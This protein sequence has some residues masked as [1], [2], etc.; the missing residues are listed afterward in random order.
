MAKKKS[1]PTPVPPEPL[2]PLFDA[3]THLYST[4]RKIVASRGVEIKG[5]TL[6]DEE[7]A[8]GV[9]EIMDR[10]QAVGVTHACTV[11]DG[12]EETVAAVRAAEMDPRVYAAVAVHPTLAH[13]VTDHVKTQLEDLAAHPRCVAIGETGLDEYWIGK[14]EDTA[15]LE[16]Q[17]EIFRWH[18][19]LAVRTGK[20]LMIHN[21]EA[22][23]NLLR[24]LDYAPKPETVI[25]HCFSSPLDVAR[26]FLERG[27]VL[28]FCGNTTFKRNEELRQAAAEAPQGQFLVETD[29]PFMTPEPFRGARNESA[30]VGYTARVVAEARGCAPEEVALQ[31]SE[32]AR[33][34][35]G[36]A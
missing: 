7:Y 27:Y 28:S 21:R 24:V 35:F 6:T 25:M 2:H 31:S 5:R 12:L 36:L 17:E 8:A 14:D 18:I 1:R 33:R 13:T 4:V 9:Q 22:D 29:A 26:E 20:A 32:T 15:P 19:D 10:A 16:V 11:G 34:V 3:H 23:Q 30:Y